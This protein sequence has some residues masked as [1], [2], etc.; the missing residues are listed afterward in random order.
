MKIL[1]TGAAGFI[2][3]NLAEYLLNNEHEVIGVDNFNNF[4]N[5]KIKEYNIKDFAKNE[6]FLLERTDLTD[7]VALEKVFVAQKNIDA[8]VHLAA[9]PGVTKSFDTPA[10]YVRHNIEATIN[11]LEM[12]KKY[13][14]KNFIF[15]SSSSVY[16]DGITPF[17]ETMSTD[18]PL[19]PYPATK[20]S[21]EVLLYS[22]EIG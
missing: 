3:S 7:T 14:P 18:F 12:C 16:G 5:P 1:V 21:C 20:K 13:G 22:Y 10:L 6:K 19:A 15:A 2:G 17:V 4:Y 11:L 9:L 8:V